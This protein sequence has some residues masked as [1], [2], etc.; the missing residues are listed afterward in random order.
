[1]V[2]IAVFEPGTAI[3]T[4]EIKMEPD[5]REGRYDG[6]YSTYYEARYRRR[7]INRKKLDC[8]ESYQILS[9]GDLSEIRNLL[10]DMWDSIRND[11]Q[12]INIQDDIL[13]TQKD[14]ITDLEKHIDRSDWEKP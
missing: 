5:R 10:D 13:H 11:S 6:L 12:I 4:G 14:Y 2:K 8:T 7:C 3:C 9:R 1:M